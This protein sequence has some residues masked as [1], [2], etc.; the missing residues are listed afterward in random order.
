MKILPIVALL[1]TSASSIRLYS[2][3]DKPAKEAKSP[4]ASTEAR[5]HDGSAVDPDSASGKVI[6]NSAKHDHDIISQDRKLSDIVQG[7]AVVAVGPLDKP[8]PVKKEIEGITEINK[9]NKYFQTEN[10]QLSL[11]Q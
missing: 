9:S 5:P 10:D 7:K 6:H 2:H 4:R 3:D 1:L 8:F 11:I